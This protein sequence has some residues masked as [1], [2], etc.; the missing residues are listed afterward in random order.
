[1]TVVVSSEVWKPCLDIVPR[2]S[3]L[4]GT[5]GTHRWS[6]DDRDHQYKSIRKAMISYDKLD[7]L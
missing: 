5:H 2:C 1:M 6:D 3:K 4:R 7:K